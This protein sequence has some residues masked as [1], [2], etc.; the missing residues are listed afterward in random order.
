MWQFHAVNE[1]IRQVPVDKALVLV[2]MALVIVETVFDFH[3]AVAA[4]V[5]IDRRGSDMEEVAQV[6]CSQTRTEVAAAVVRTGVV[7]C[8]AIGLAEG[9]DS[10]LAAQKRSGMEGY[11]QGMPDRD[12]P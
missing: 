3:T 6:C 9:T 12:V 2:G 8:K 10:G 1:H 7:H 11:C 5:E 4:E